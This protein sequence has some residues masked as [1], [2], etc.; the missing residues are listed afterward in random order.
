MNVCIYD[1]IHVC[2][3]VSLCVYKYA[4]MMYIHKSI[5]TSVCI[6]R[7]VYVFIYVFFMYLY[8]HLCIYICTHACMHAFV[9][10]DMHTC[11][12]TCLAYQRLSILNWQH[13]QGDISR[14]FFL[15]IYDGLKILL[16]FYS[17]FVYQ[18]DSHIISWCLF[19]QRTWSTDQKDYR[20]NNQC[21]WFLPPTLGKS[22][23]IS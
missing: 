15:S 6:Y 13:V 9:H 5:H 4:Y 8:M 10:G 3:C 14:L 11:S 17:R 2:M 1:C 20:A 21:C 19:Q 16:Y 7:C 12:D 22:L 18:L 23:T